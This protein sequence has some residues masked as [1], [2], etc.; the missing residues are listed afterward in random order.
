MKSHWPSRRALVAGAA[1]LP[2]AAQEP[3]DARAYLS[4]ILY[5]RKEVDDWFAGRAFPFARFDAEL[6][7]LLRDARF[8][9]GVDGSTSTYVYGPFDERQMIRYR[10]RPCRINTYGNSYTQCHQVSDGETWQEVLAAHIGE[11]V[12]NFGVGGWSVYQAYLR[13][14]R[15]EKRA[16]ARFIIFNIYVDD[17]YRNLDSWRN[18]RVRKHANFIE[19]TLPHLK[20]DLDTGS[21][22]RME[23]PCP[24]QEAYYRLCDLD[25]VERRFRDDFALG[26]MLA[27][28][29][30]RQGNPESAYQALS[31]LARTHGIKTRL[32]DGQTLSAAADQ[33]HTRAALLST[34]KIVDWIEEFRR[35]HGKT[36]LYVLSCP[37][38]TIGRFVKE[39]FRPDG[40]F[41]EFLVR[42]GLP[43]IDLLDA[44]VRDFQHFSAPIEIYLKRF[45]IGHYNPLGN[46]FTAFS[47]KDKLVEMLDPKPPAYR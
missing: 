22:A 18:I 32:D 13:M 26:I 3:L 2:A 16:P 31:D 20:V 36:V 1:A 38:Q 30:A 34:M 8:R 43:F 41:R 24:T 17:H 29:R 37:A 5:T 15:E 25:W 28:A 39:G 21:C 4:R 46:W 11:P 10:E 42:R 45:F 35:A 33:L 23:N 14:L 27:H 7:W 40:E 47:I 9:D 44:H 12:R 19:P 6:G